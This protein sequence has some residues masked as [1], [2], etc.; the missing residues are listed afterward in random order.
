[1]TRTD[2]RAVIRERTV[3]E[4]R[5]RHI[6]GDN[7]A[8]FSKGKFLTLGGRVSGCVTTFTTKDCLLAEIYEE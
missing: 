3:E 2:A 4:K 8:T 1:M 7:G 6:H 5:R